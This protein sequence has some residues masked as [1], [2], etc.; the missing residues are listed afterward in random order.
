MSACWD[1]YPLVDW[2]FCRSTITLKDE[3][4]VEGRTLR[5]LATARGQSMSHVEI[6]LFDFET[7]VP[8]PPAGDFFN[9]DIV[10]GNRLEIRFSRNTVSS[11]C[12]AALFRFLDLSALRAAQFYRHPSVIQPIESE[13][14]LA[15]Y[16]EFE[17]NKGERFIIAGE[18]AAPTLWISDKHGQTSIIDLDPKTSDWLLVA[19]HC[20]R[21]SNS[22]QASN[23]NI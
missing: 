11:I 3:S 19:L 14:K 23:G 7:S 16:T 22:E 6:A 9:I 21:K 4:E 17:G 18:E 20:I 5:I 15:G 12:K 10:E 2:I 1:D 8:L 13:M